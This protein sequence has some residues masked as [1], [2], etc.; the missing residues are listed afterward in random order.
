M[1][2]ESERAGFSAGVAREILRDR[3]ATDA[4]RIFVTDSH[5]EKDAVILAGPLKTAKLAPV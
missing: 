3:P 5:D 4:Y 2:A 1:T